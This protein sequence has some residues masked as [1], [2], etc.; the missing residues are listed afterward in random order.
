M[1]NRRKIKKQ[2]PEKEEESSNEEESENI[3]EYQEDGFVVND[4]VSEELGNRND[5]RLMD[6]SHSNKDS[7]SE[8]NENEEFEESFADS[9]I[10]IAN[11]Q[12]VGKRKLIKKSHRDI[13]DDT[14]IDKLELEQKKFLEDEDKYIKQEN[15]D[16]LKHKNKYP[17]TTKKNIKQNTEKID[18]FEEE[19]I[20]KNESDEYKETHDYQVTDLRKYYT[21]NELNEGYANSYDQVIKNLDYPERLLLRYKEEDLPKLQDEIEYETEWMIERLGLHINKNDDY[22][23]PNLQDNFITFKK[24][25]K[26]VLELYKVKYYDCPYIVTYKQSVYKTE[27]TENDV[28][29]IFALDRTWQLITEYK[30]NVINQYEYVSKIL[31]NENMEHLKERYINRAKSIRELKNMEKYIYFLKEK[32]YKDYQKEF[33]STNIDSDYKLPLKK[34]FIQEGVK[35]KLREFCEAFSMS[36]NDVAENLENI[37]NNKESSSLIKPPEPNM[38][39]AEL[40]KNLIGDKYSTELDLMNDACK[41]AALEL[42]CHPYIREYVFDFFKQNSILS[43]LPT[44]RGKD[45]L[46][47]FNPSFRTKRINGKRICQFENDLYFDIDLTEKKNLINY[48][49]SLSDNDEDM[50]LI[51]TKL[52]NAYASNDN[53]ELNADW[54]LIR[55]E[56]ISELVKKILYKEFQT[57]I[58][59]DLKEQAEDYIIEECAKKFGDLLNAGPYRKNIDKDNNDEKDVFSYDDLPKVM[60]LVYDP[61]NKKTYCVLLS[62]NGEVIDHYIFHYVAN[63]T[64][65]VMKGTEKEFFD[66]EIEKYKGLIK[67]YNPDLIIIGANDLHSKILRDQIIFSD[68]QEQKEDKT[69]SWTTYGDLAIP[70]IYANSPYSEKY[71]KFYD[72]SLRQAI[73]LGR[74]QQ[75]P[76]DEIL[77]LWN[78]DPSRNFCLKINLHPFQHYVNQKKLMDILE[79]KAVRIVNEV[80][81]D[82]NLANEYP[83]LRNSLM[84]VSGLGPRKAQYLIEKMINH[85]GLY[86]RL[87]LSYYDILTKKVFE[88]CN[89]FL[90]IKPNFNESHKN[91]EL[92]DMTRIPF[93]MYSLANKFIK[94]ALE[95]ERLRES[96]DKT[97]RILKDPQKLENVDINEFIKKQNDSN[98]TNILELRYNIQLIK[99]EL[100]NPFKDSRKVRQDLNANEIFLLLVGDRTFK[101]GQIT[102]ATVIKVDHE[103][104][105]C[106]LTNGLEATVW[107]NDISDDKYLCTKEEM[108]NRYK[109]GTTFE[110]RIT[111]INEN[112]FKVDLSTK[113]SVMLTHKDYIN[114]ESLDSFKLI[115]EEDLINKKYKEREENQQSKYVPRKIFHE[116]FK[117]LT[118]KSCMEYLS[119]K[120]IGECIFRPSKRGT[121]NLTLSWKFSKK[122]VCHV[123]IIEQDKSNGQFLGHKLIIG[124]EVY[125]SL[126]E[127]CNRYVKPCERFVKDVI[128]SRKFYDCDTKNDIINK[129]RQDKQNDPSIIHYLFAILPEFPQYIILAYIPKVELIFEYIKVKPIGFIFHGKT[130]RDIDEVTSYFKTNFFSAEYSDYVRKTPPPSIIHYKSIKPVIQ[131]QSISNTDYHDSSR[132]HRSKIGSQECRYCHENGHF[133][134]ECPKKRQ[135]YKSNSSNKDYGRSQK[136]INNKRNRDNY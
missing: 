46:D 29:K 32:Y 28:W 100:N 126:N 110:A 61:N 75:S 52:F 65:K 112:N 99:A 55:E 84:F 73:S 136:F 59:E 93:E 27:L 64:A 34:S 120:D 16:D 63:K 9:D 86:M 87:Q 96:E 95:S 53:S 48:T 12:K 123:D 43:S 125:G 77:Q 67:Q 74:Y 5:Y 62:K 115:K 104:V 37:K 30:K 116:K 117:N 108:E 89:G 134:K 44:E 109:T 131:N 49:I 6:I 91:Y 4:N 11:Q 56:V 23:N 127:I 72:F 97:K 119:N 80:G 82:V 58:R 128:N 60:S 114:V 111:N 78:E 24:K 130:F 54:G 36:A 45:E 94:T 40:A 105:K 76:L 47:V 122:V 26:N 42:S 113:P 10:E 3:N 107:V 133:A 90:K 33:D 14:D 71:F 124:N 8:S 79:L 35:N 69:K 129:L 81:V 83:H 92:L 21:A 31:V 98:N 13:I 88:N 7:E 101:E 132:V 103:H 50:K 1:S 39:P 15:K 102:V 70:T 135:D 68:P 85:N 2:K 106:K 38:S 25:I 118:Y 121:N 41:F 51:S 57:E 66:E 20:I 18:N 19:D 17:Q 22:R